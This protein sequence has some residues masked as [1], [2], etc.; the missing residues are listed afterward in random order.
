[1]VLPSSPSAVIAVQSIFLFFAWT[2]AVLRL[3]AHCFVVKKIDWNDFFLIVTLCL[4]S[5]FASFLFTV[6]GV[7]DYERNSHLY[8]RMPCK[9]SEYWP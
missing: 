5:C 6:A 2:F 3:I 7:Y 1:M 4:Y 9:Q 8:H